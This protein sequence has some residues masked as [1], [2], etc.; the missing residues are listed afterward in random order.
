MLAVQ[1]PFIRQVVEASRT[2]GRESELNALLSSAEQNGWTDLVPV[3]RRILA[4]QRDSGVLRGLDEE[5]RVIAEAI[6]RGLQ[7]PA[8]L[9]LSDPRPDP[10]MAAPGLASMI[11]EAAQGD[12]RA[13]QIISE[14]AQQ[15]SRAGGD[16]AR[17]AAVVRPLINGERDPDRLSKGMSARGEQ[18]L[19]SILAELAQTDVH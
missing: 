12:V 9:P 3:L 4:G 8:S 14:M 18:L 2:P 16:M 6:L 13:L 5:D 1:G 7:N 10:A 17:L 11:R 19:L 15:M